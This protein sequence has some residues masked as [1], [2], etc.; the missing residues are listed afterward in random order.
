MMDVTGQMDARGS[1]SHSIPPSDGLHRCVSEG[2]G[3]NLRGSL[4]E[5]ILEQ[6]GSQQLV[7]T[8]GDSDSSP[9]NEIQSEEPD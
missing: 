9:G 2:L 5:R 3:H 1:V 8:Q 6:R 7:G 4:L